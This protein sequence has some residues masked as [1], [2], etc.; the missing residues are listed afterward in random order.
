MTRL[1]RGMVVDERL[2]LQDGD[3]VRLIV[4]ADR[5]GSVQRIANHPAKEDA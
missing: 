4:P 1:G 5:A 3:E 2:I